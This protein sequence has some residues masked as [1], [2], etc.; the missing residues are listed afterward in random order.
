MS[1]LEIILLAIALAM[2]CFAVSI[3]C[4][5]LLKQTDWATQFRIAFLFGLFQAVMPLFGWLL[6]ASFS[7][8]IT[9]FDHWIAFGLLAFLG[10]KMIWESLHPEEEST[11]NPHHL[12]TQITLAIATSIDALAVGISFACLG[13]ET[14]SQLYSPLIWIGTA[15]FILSMAGSILGITMGKKI[16]HFLKPELI[17]GLILLAIGIRILWEHLS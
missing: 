17:G 11:F 14:V 10:G 9:S 6:T 3:V 13:Y 8:Y 12:K 2:D 5:I 7:S 16:D 15:S 4:G 1:L